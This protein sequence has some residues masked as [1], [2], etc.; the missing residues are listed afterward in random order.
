MHTLNTSCEATRLKLSSIRRSTFE[1]HAHEQHGEDRGR[2]VQCLDKKG[3][4]AQAIL[5]GVA[6]RGLMIRQT[7]GSSRGSRGDKEK[8]LSVTA[9][10]RVNPLPQV[11]HRS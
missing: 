7:A 9:L 6:V 2:D 3:E 10:S 1:Q 11:L 4:H 8:F 5:E